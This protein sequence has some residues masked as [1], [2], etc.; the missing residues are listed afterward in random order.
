[1]AAERAQGSWESFA[2]SAPEPAA[3]ARALLERHGFVLLGTVRRDGTPRISPVEV[4]FVGEQLMLV[5]VPN[6]RKAEDVRRDARVV[7]QSP[8]TDPHDP[9]PELKVRAQAREI[10]D[11]ELRSAVADV[12]EQSSGWRP[13][14]S[15]LFL[16][17]S[18]NEV[19][20]IRWRSDGSATVARWSARSSATSSFEIALDV[21]RG[22][23]V[24]S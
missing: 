10:G 11:E 12:V 13:A 3:D 18:L 24:R 19:T 22:T 6:S 8:V 4:H 2:R 17:L 16:A 14:P 20:W 9:G 15:W 23:Y 7:L 21:E 1:M 5:L